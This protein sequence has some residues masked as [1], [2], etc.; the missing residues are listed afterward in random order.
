[1]LGFE[2]SPPICGCLVVY[3]GFEVSPPI[4]GYLVVLL[5][6][7]VSPLICGYLFVL[8]FWYLFHMSYP[9]V[10]VD[11]LSIN[12]SHVI[13][14]HLGR[15]YI[16]SDGSSLFFSLVIKQLILDHFPKL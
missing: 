16:K 11:V 6:F 4:Y 15:S 3:L 8:G 9:V 12:S 2:V 14:K 13:M 1:M 5:G 7:E 10:V